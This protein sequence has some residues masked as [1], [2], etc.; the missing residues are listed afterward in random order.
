M[1]HE[2]A[3]KLFAGTYIER[4]VETS[5]R[6]ASHIAK[7]YICLHMCGQEGRID[8]ASYSVVKIK[9]EA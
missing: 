9:N 2:I 7:Q 6:V 1:P 8:D 5:T 4:L 3:I